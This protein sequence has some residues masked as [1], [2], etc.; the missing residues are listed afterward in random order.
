MQ[1]RHMD[2]LQRSDITSRH[3]DRLVVSVDIWVGRLGYK[4]LTQ[5]TDYDQRRAE[6]V[7]VILVGERSALATI[8]VSRHVVM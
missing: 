7:Q 4:M 5:W 8:I 2:F 6:V 1:K 3:R